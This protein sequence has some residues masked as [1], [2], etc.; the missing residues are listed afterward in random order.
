MKEFEEKLSEM[1]S[2]L[3]ELAEYSMTECK[4]SAAECFPMLSHK[5]VESNGKLYG[6]KMNIELVE[7]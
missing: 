3:V 6:L 7:L 2:D 4:V 1:L 5:Q